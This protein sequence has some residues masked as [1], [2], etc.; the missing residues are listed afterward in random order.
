[1]LQNPELTTSEGF[2]SHRSKYHWKSVAGNQKNVCKIKS[3]KIEAH[4]VA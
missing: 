3:Q 2:D 1:M 4:M